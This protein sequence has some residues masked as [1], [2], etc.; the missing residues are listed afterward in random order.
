MVIYFTSKVRRR[1]C[2]EVYVLVFLRAELKI[3]IKIIISE[4]LRI[5]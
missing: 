5:P 3:K 1:C 2:E 4:I